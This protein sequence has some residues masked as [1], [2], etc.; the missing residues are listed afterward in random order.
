MN[1][2]GVRGSLTLNS[3]WGSKVEDHKDPNE[4]SSQITAGRFDLGPL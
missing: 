3:A 2:Y 4:I 1:Q